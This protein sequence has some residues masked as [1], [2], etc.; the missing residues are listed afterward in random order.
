[1]Q[2]HV[3]TETLG[4]ESQVLI[5]LSTVERAGQSVQCST[6]SWKPSMSASPRLTSFVLL[7]ARVKPA[8][9]WCE[10]SRTCSIVIIPSCPQGNPSTQSVLL[11]DSMEDACRYVRYP[12]RRRNCSR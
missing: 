12:L 3:D 7:E 11:D 1:M 2:K 4:F 8:T 6:T 10:D 5:D 9:S